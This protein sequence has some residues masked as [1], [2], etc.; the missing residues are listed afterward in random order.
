M[1][2]HSSSSI[3]PGVVRELDKWNKTLRGTEN[4]LEVKDMVQRLLGFRWEEYDIER[5]AARRL[6]P[7]A[8]AINNAKGLLGT[9][10]KYDIKEQYDRNYVKLNQDREGILKKITG[11]Y[12]NLKVLGLDGEQALNVLDKTALSTNDK[13]ESITGYYSPMPYE[14]PLTKTE[15]YES[16]ETP[17]SNACSQSGQCVGKEWILGRLKI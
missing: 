2:M 16:L 10:R 14:Q 11:H 12:N 7:D 8:T 9:S 6:A 15:I 3:E 17:Q 5:D 13:F 4:A 1:P